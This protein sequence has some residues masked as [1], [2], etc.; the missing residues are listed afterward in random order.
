MLNKISL[1]V[2]QVIQ[3]ITIETDLPLISSLFIEFCSNLQIISLT[4]LPFLQAKFDTQNKLAFSIGKVLSS[5][6]PFQ[7]FYD[8]KPDPIFRIIFILCCLYLAFYFALLI[9]V[10]SKIILRRKPPKPLAKILSI[11]SYIHCKGIFYLIHCF[12]VSTLS[13]E[14]PK[15][16]SKLLSCRMGMIIGTGFIFS[17]NLILALLQ[18]FFC[19]QIHHNTQSNGIKNNTHH[20]SKLLHKLLIILLYYLL[21][22]SAEILII[23]N[24]L[25]TIVDT[26]TLHI[27]LPFYHIKM[28]YL[29][30]ICS[31]ISAS[32]ALFSIGSLFVSNENI[33][34]V[35]MFATPLLVKGSLII[36]Q[37]TF[38]DIILLRFSNPYQAVHLPI[39]LCYYSVNWNISPN[40]ERLR[41]KALYIMGFLSAKARGTL[42]LATE[43]QRISHNKALKEMT[44]LHQKH[45]ENDLILITIAQIY[46]QIFNDDYT[47]LS[48]MSKSGNEVTSFAGKLSLQSL[49]NSL[50]A[51]NTTHIVEEETHK[52][53]YLN[54]FTCREKTRILKKHIQAEIQ[55]H[56]NLWKNLD[57]KEINILNAIYQASKITKQ[58]H[59]ILNYWAQ[60]FENQEAL[61]V[62]ASIIYALYLEIVRAIPSSGASLLKKAQRSINNKWHINRDVIDI[63][64]GNSAIIVASIESDK[65]GK[66]IDASSSATE[67]FKTNKQG[68]IGLKIGQ[69]LPHVLASKHN[70]LIKGF[71]KNSKETASFENFVSYAKTLQDDYF[72]VQ[73]TLQPFPLICKELSLFAYIKKASDYQSILVV[74][75]R[76]LIIEFSKNLSLP[77]NLHTRKSHSVKIES[78]CSTFKMINQAF[79]L[80]Y[81]SQDFPRQ[82]T[83]KYVDFPQT[84]PKLAYDA[85]PSTLQRMNIQSMEDEEIPQTQKIDYQNNKFTFPNE[86]DY[87]TIARGF[88]TKSTMTVEQAQMIWGQYKETNELTFSPYT[89][90]KTLISSDIKYQTKIEPFYFDDQWYQVIELKQNLSSASMATGSDESL[91]PFVKRNLTNKENSFAD[92]FPHEKER[93]YFINENQPSKENKTPSGSHHKERPSP[94]LKPEELDLENHQIN[95]RRVSSQARSIA[96][97]R[98]TENFVKAKLNSLKREPQS[99]S[100]SFLSNMITFT[101]LCLIC[102]ILIHFIYTNK[103]LQEMRDSNNLTML[104]NAR[105]SKTILNW[106]AMLIL[107]SRSSQ[108]RPIDYRIP[109]YQEVMK[110]SSLDVINNA[111]DLSE[112]VDK[113]GNN[114]ITR[115]LYAKAVSLWEPLTHTL[116]NN[117]PVDQFSA[118]QVLIDYYLDIARYNGSFLNL[119]NDREMLFTV[120]N[121][122]N[123]YLL[124]IDASIAYITNFFQKTKNDNAALLKAIAVIEIL[125][126]VIPVILIPIILTNLVKKYSKLFQTLCKLQNKS[127][128]QRLTKLE[129]IS[130]LFDESLEDNVSVYFASSFSSQ[131]QHRNVAETSADVNKRPQSTSLI[132]TNRREYS[133]KTLIVYISKYTFF[134]VILTLII[135][136]LVIFA[137]QQ[138]IQNLHELDTINKKAL[139]ASAV[140]SQIQMLL[141]SFYF[142]IIL[143]NDTSYKVRNDVPFKQLLLQYQ[144]LGNANNLL[145]DAFSDSN[146]EIADPTIKDIF[147]GNPCKYV[148]DTYYNDCLIKSQGESFG[149]F[150]LQ[151]LFSQICEPMKTFASTPNPTFQLGITLSNI[152]SATNNNTHFVIYD[153][154][155][156]IL[157]YLTASFIDLT[158]KKKKEMLKILVYTLVVGL[159]GLRVIS[160]VILKRLK[161]LDLGIRRILR[162]IPDTVVQQNKIIGFYLA[163]HFPNEFSVPPSNN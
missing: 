48:Y 132:S 30:I 91:P 29:A 154:Y 10:I 49:S 61:Y 64:M 146:N 17:F 14:C 99:K 6:E 76:G 67:M 1:K 87:P 96:T 38:E 160:M 11:S 113:L 74:D 117:Q 34:L 109:K 97:S 81:K 47:A 33:Y 147:A 155:N 141:P 21:E 89:G 150:G 37:K 40:R 90:N 60:N 137:F 143:H 152:Y 3:E 115:V 95:F 8:F 110:N 136:G 36:L 16:S 133:V 100:F 116:F 53:S 46:S 108:L 71:Q 138:S 31:T 72:K 145:I 102:A 12:T 77:L 78:L 159:V 161:M 130:N 54:Y 9:L 144:V 35:I 58:V 63:A 5:L 73:V 129:E 50:T 79:N 101:L 119:V 142:S 88:T 156:Y 56:L 93:S 134:A 43:V 111:K 32:F 127:L 62:N 66:I 23:F 22:N 124:T 82:E 39:L 158:E 13:Q 153:L 51:G 128:T 27:R 84:S 131:L 45:P 157:D 69:V 162:V 44:R 20:I 121:T 120:N 163:R 4:F 68:L 15:N 18:E 118:N 25:F 55:Q 149:L 86:Y 70:D 104:V 125:V 65:I 57:H 98:L 42:F 52:K 112:A 135:I 126:I 85:V 59:K 123:S 24:I 80:L 2:T 92:E 139:A 151:S 103:S 28:L 107:Y 7:I 148:T 83:A 75:H 122:A 106:Q 41:Q 26:F 114:D 19:Y 140:L 94:A 105:L